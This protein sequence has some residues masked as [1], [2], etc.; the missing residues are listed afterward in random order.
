[1]LTGYTKPIELLLSE[2]KIALM[3]RQLDLGHIL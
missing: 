2:M 3:V 1:M